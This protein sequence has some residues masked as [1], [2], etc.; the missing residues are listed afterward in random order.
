MWL[1]YLPQ[2]LNPTTPTWVVETSGRPRTLVSSENARS[3]SPSGSKCSVAPCP[4]APTTTFGT[5]PTSPCTFPK[6][7]RAPS[8]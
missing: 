3:C 1:V 4:G 2:Y 8:P 5:H 7:T 6:T